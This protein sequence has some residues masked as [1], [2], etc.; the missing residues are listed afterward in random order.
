LLSF[1]SVIIIVKRHLLKNDCIQEGL[2]RKPKV[3]IFNAD[4]P[5]Y[6]KGDKN[7]AGE[8]GKPVKINQEQLSAQEREKYAAG[9]RNNAFNQYVSDMI[10]IH[11]SLPSTIDEE[12]L[13]S[14][15]DT[16]GYG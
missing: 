9:F 6:K 10:S 11:R 3:F 4:S 2:L 7:Q 15:V 12:E 14:M 8:G 16:C 5:I 13:T 1:L